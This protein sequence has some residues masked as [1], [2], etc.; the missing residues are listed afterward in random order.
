MAEVE[1]SAAPGAISDPFRNY[2]FAVVIDGSLEAKFTSVTGL[3][4]EMT[5]IK[6]REGGS[7]GGVRMIPG[8]V[9]NQALT[10]AYGETASQDMFAWMLACANGNVDRRDVSIV[11]FDSTG[12]QEVLRYELDRC[13]PVKFSASELNAVGGSVAIAALT[14]VYEGIERVVTRPAAPTASTPTPAT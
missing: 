11:M 14:L 10:L 9:D 1:A 3:G 12:T 6:Y 13:F 4:I 5:P 8:Q 7:A 2:N